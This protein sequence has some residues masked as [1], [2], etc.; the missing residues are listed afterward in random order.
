MPN[1]QNLKPWA[2]GQSGNPKGR[3]REYF[4]YIEL[5]EM[6]GTGTVPREK[7][8]VYI[9]KAMNRIGKD[10]NAYERYLQSRQDK[11]ESVGNPKA[12]KA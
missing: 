10:R 4:S 8:S 5:A 6:A 11:R 3:P 12:D 9:E 2:K 7:F 1:P